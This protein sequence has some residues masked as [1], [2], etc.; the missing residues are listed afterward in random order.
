MHIRVK[1]LAKLLGRTVSAVCVLIKLSAST[2]KSELDLSLLMRRDVSLTEPF[3]PVVVASGIR[4]AK[5]KFLQFCVKKSV[6]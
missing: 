1:R 3:P 2:L 6:K 4:G 5:T